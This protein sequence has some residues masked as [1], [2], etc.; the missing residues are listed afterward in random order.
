[1]CD[2][3]GVV[4]MAGYDW[5]AGKSNNA[6]A[7]EESGLL[8]AGRAG[9]NARSGLVRTWMLTRHGV[10]SVATPRATL[11]RARPAGARATRLSLRRR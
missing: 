4:A 2:E 6:V 11:S 3:D 10:A 8:T 7:A 1:M 9:S 5:D